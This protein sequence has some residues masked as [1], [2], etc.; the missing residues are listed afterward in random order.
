MQSSTFAA[1]AAFGGAVF[2]LAIYHFAVV[3]PW[4]RRLDRA[5]RAHDELLGGGERTGTAR[6][7]SLEE[8]ARSHEAGAGRV[9]QRLLELE[10]LARSDV[11]R[12]G[13]IRY[14][15]FADTG[16]ELSYALALLSREGNGVV[17]SSIFSREDTRTFGKAVQGYRP[18]QDASKEELSAIAQ[19]R[20]ENV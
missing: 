10:R 2:A 8:A 12:V 4:V 5:R 9:E 7:S 20:G 19:A 14:N 6:L 1:L 13:F 18:L 17:V 16:S 11:S 3:A 15:A